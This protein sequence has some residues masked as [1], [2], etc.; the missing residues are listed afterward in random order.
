M[1]FVGIGWC[2]ILRRRQS[3]VR[4]IASAFHHIGWLGEAAAL[5]SRAA[6][7]GMFCLTQKL[8]GPALFRR[9]CPEASIAAAAENTDGPTVRISDK[10]LASLLSKE[11]SPIAP[12]QRCGHLAE[13]GERAK[14]KVSGL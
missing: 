8:S 2:D 13:A 14:R 9:H 4:T 3:K 5:S 11:S 7:S 10:Q 12:T 1:N 6:T